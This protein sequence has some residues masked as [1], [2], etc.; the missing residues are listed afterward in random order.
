MF[1]KEIGQIF[2]SWGM[3]EVMHKV[4]LEA[5]KATFA[6]VNFIDVSVDEATTTNNT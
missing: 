2:S 3:V 4:L 5:T 1:L 6:Y